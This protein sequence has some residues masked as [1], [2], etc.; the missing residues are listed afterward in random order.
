MKTHPNPMRSA[1]RIALLLAA[2]LTASHG[3][4]VGIPAAADLQVSENG[5]V[6]GASSPTNPVVNALNDQSNVDPLLRKNEIIALRF[7]LTGKNRLQSTKAYLKLINSKRNSTTGG[8][9]EFYGVNNGAKGY[10]Q[11]GTPGAFTDNDWPEN[12]TVFSTTPGLRFDADTSTPGVDLSLTTYLG[13]VAV[14]N[15]NRDEGAEFILATA[16]LHDFLTNHEDEVVT[17]LVYASNNNPSQKRFATKEATS[18]D[19]ILTPVAAGTYAPRLYLDLPG[20]TVKASADAQVGEVNGAATTTYNIGS[21]TGENLNSRYVTTAG[22]ERNEVIALRFDLT[23]IAPD[24]ITAADLRLV[25]YRLNATSAN[26]IHIY[27]VNDEA[28]GLHSVDGEG[29]YTDDDWQDNSP[30]LV[31]SAIPGLYYD[32]SVAVQ[33]CVVQNRV[34]DLG[35]TYVSANNLNFDEGVELIYA[36]EKLKNFLINHPD[37]IVTILLVADAPASNNQK[38]FASKEAF[39]LN[40]GTGVGGVWQAGDPVVPVGTYAPSLNLIVAPSDN[41]RITNIT[42][43]SGTGQISLTWTSQPGE[44]FR[45]THSQ[46]LLDGFPGVTATNIP[47]AA[48]TTTS[49]TFPNPVPAAQKLFFRVERP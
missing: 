30:G 33:D 16:A 43:S 23:N 19:T 38:R 22:G 48:G 36:N 37:R 25:N 41:F 49:L 7:D 9:L 10:D 35:T 2:S 1:A 46:T 20:T 17:I 4:Q 3:V 12:G 5:G 6:D 27:G 45:I 40:S 28:R 24:K 26:P 44:V 13:I 39:H 11:S 21:G 34:T 47:A 29:A 42:P 14:D 15:G 31:F 32:G 8:Q 18:L